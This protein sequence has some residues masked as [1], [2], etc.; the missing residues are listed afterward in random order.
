LRKR[1]SICRGRHTTPEWRG[2][3]LQ[4]NSIG[5]SRISVDK[6]AQIVVIIYFAELRI[7]SWRWHRWVI[8]TFEVDRCSPK[9]FK[10]NG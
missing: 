8:C 4:E 3:G 7:S 5:I 1:E 6:H 2:V 10:V 9:C